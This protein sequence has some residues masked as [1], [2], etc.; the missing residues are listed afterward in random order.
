MGRKAV[1]IAFWILGFAFGEV[2]W[3]MKTPVLQTIEN[4]GIS[5]DASQA[6]LAGFFG[7]VV[8]VL[9]VLAWS[10]LSSST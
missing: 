7:S 4:L 3:Y 10:F 2:A 5:A 6:L 9:A 1:I 8:M